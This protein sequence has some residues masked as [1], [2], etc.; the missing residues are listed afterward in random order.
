LTV[1]S[2]R[3]AGISPTVV[4][5][6]L[7]ASAALTLVL[8]V[9]A[10]AQPG[11]VMR[12]GSF[13]TAGGAQRP[14]TVAGLTEVTAVDASNASAY[15]LESNGSV[16]AWGNNRSG[17]L[18][19]PVNEG[20]PGRAVQVPLPAGVQATTI[21][22]AEFVGIAI[23]STGHAWA[24]GGSG[25]TACLGRFAGYELP[26]TEVPGIANAVAVQGGG[27]HTIWLLSNGTVETCGNNE[28]GQLGVPNIGGSGSPVQVPGL[29][30]VVEISAAERTT[31]A[32]TASGAVYDWG[33]DDDGQI[34]NGEETNGVFQPFKVP[35][36]GPATEISCGGNVESDDFTLALVN[37]QV[38]GWGADG[39]G[40]IGN[41]VSQANQLAPV[42]TGLHFARV[43]AGGSTGYGLTESGQVFSW[44]GAFESSLGTGK[45][46]NNPTPSL[47]D[48]GVMSISATAHDAIDLH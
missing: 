34:G 28:S 9:A 12:W 43:V 17:Q 46:R 30:E 2:K 19:V 48:E 39:A 42:A 29:S 18:G 45:S 47:V 31:C 27:H 11:A 37:G 21:G 8:P 38:Y 5:S 4:L 6:S 32:R 25:P 40:Q 10:S 44:G 20:N 26:P 15:A 23:D 3:L 35:L 14:T 41:G 33:A 7:L 1:R 16:W 22:E 13:G 36:P 24:W